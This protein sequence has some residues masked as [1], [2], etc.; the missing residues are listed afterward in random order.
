MDIESYINDVITD[1][2]IFNITKDIRYYN[3][4]NHHFIGVFNKNGSI[5]DYKF[6]I[7]IKKYDI[8]KLI[9]FG[10]FDDIY[11]YGTKEMLDNTNIM[12][13][14]KERKKGH[15]KYDKATDIY[16]TNGYVKTESFNVFGYSNE[17]EEDLFLNR[18]EYKDFT[19]YHNNMCELCNMRK[20]N[21]L[22]PDT[23]TYVCLTCDR[24]IFI[25]QRKE[26]YY[27][28]TK[29][30]VNNRIPIKNN[31]ILYEDKD[32]LYSKELSIYNQTIS[33]NKLDLPV[34]KDYEIDY[35]NSLYPIIKNILEHINYRYITKEMILNFIK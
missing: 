32:E 25:K 2:T 18:H 10:Y 31:T 6:G 30:M 15:F 27:F 28:N 35:Y 9:L 22:Y 17:K 24:G 4:K 13:V 7:L 8:F 21:I 14:N 19:N 1:Y 26:R 11:F 20:C 16:N 3:E 23:K 33:L 34:I 12:N 5:V 29:N